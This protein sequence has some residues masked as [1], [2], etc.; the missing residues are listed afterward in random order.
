MRIVGE[1]RLGRNR[2]NDPADLMYALI[3]PFED[4]DRMRLVDTI[5][6]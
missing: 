5:Q 2:S 3:M 6:A 4:I 1:M